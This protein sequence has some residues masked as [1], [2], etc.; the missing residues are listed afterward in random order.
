MIG[1]LLI[2]LKSK[3]ATIE[4]LTAKLGGWLATFLFMWMPLP[5]IYNIL[6]KGEPAAASLSMGFVMLLTLG[7]GLGSTR[8]FYIKE[9]VWFTGAFWGLI[10]GGW[11]TLAVT[12]NAAPQKCSWQ[13]LLCYTIMLCVYFITIIVFNG[14]AKSESIGRQLSFLWS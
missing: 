4:A 11:L 10:V 6:Q 9:K 8:A 1:S 5:Q 13:A 12:C 7:N 3:F 14:A 2:A